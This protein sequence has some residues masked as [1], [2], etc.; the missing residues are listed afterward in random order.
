MALKE[1]EVGFTSSPTCVREYSVLAQLI[2]L[3]AGSAFKWL[4][5]AADSLDASNTPVVEGYEGKQDQMQGKSLF[6]SLLCHL[7]HEG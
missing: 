1:M 5:N 3:S 2:W 4:N 6:H 7:G